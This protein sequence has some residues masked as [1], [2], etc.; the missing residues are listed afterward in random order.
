[1]IY[2]QAILI[3]IFSIGNDLLSVKWHEARENREPFKGAF[4]SIGLGLIAW[5]ALIWVVNESRWLMV[6]DLLGTFVGSYY[7]IKYH[8]APLPIAIALGF[9]KGPEIEEQSE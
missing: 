9:Y 4:L 3:F 8:H 1:M 5:L 6:P 7:G 2:V